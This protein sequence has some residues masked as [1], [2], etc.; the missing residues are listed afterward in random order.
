MPNCVLEYTC[1]LLLN[2]R[3]VFKLVERDEPNV[4][5]ATLDKP[6]I[7]VGEIVL[8]DIAAMLRCSSFIMCM[9]LIICDVIRCECLRHSLEH[10]I[11]RTMLYVM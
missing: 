4:I 6:R 9:F 2:E 3:V 7:A 10:G 5:I 8:M 11:T 1:T